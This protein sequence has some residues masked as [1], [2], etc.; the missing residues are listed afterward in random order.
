MNVPIEARAMDLDWRCCRFDS[1]GV[2]ELQHIYA[3]RQRVFALEQQCVYLDADG[4]DE[5]AFHL[6][7]WSSRQREPL[8]YARILD[9]GVKYAEPS[10]G[11]VITFGLGRGCGLGRAVVARAIAEAV[12]AWPGQAI[13]ISA[14]TRLE[15]FYED[16][17]F[18]AVGPPYV[19]DG[20]DHTEM[21]LRPGESH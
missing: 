11:R 13:R 12:R 20:I 7:G 4:C 3:A 6:A 10:I 19:E 8:A 5:A 17:G 9:P 18:L 14:Q 16:F 1:L 2:H 15:H 21:L